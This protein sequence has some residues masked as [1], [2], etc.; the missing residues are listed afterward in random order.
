MIHI[1]YKIRRWFLGQ[2]GRNE[3]IFSDKDILLYKFPI[4]SKT[5][6]GWV[7]AN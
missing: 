6:W 2:S 1:H 4:A 7:E 3:A 5:D